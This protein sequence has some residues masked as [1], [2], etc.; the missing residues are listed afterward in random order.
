[1][2]LTYPKYKGI[3]G[4]NALLPEARPGL[5]VSNEI[6]CDVAIVGAGYTG[7]ASA[8]RW[9]ELSPGQSIA[10]LDSSVAGEG[11]PGR[12]SGFLLEIS[13]A[14]DADPAAMD[15][16][17]TCNSLIAAAMTD[18]VELVRTFDIK[19][20][21]ERTG[22]YRAA[23][24]DTGMAALES[25]AAFLDAAE[26][27]YENIDRSELQQRIGSEFYRAALFSPHCYLA[28]PAAL[29][30]GIAANLPASVKLY[31]RSPALGVQR[32]GESWR[33]ETPRG[34]VTAR[35]V[36]IANNAFAGELGFGRSRVA[37][38]Y[39][40]AG[41]TEPLQD[42]FPGCFGRGQSW[43][44][45]PAHRLGSTLRRTTDGRLLIRSCYD[46]ETETDNNKIKAIL[47]DALRRRFPLLGDVQFAQVWGGA[48]GLTFNGAPLWGEVDKNLFVSADVMVVVLLK[49]HCSAL[50]SPTW[51]IRRMFPTCRRFS[52]K[53]VGCRQARCEEL[54]SI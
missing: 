35:T 13:L 3:C 20:D 38:V 11:S 33:I 41:L 15:R 31:E 49:A 14:N 40:Y 25:Y 45:L 12:N 9:A 8:R 36:I 44:L 30:R 32:S 46:F 28:Q 2:K 18:I 1:M 42:D 21:L 10:V 6:D 39:T 16:M 4:W 5:S 51:P 24:G 48:T 7:L 54:V 17:K 37:A 34:R 50:H 19:C 23:A 29:I 53:R 27:P 26:L 43:G 52:A 22:T 47:A